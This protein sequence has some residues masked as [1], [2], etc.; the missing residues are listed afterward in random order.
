MQ[1]E[2]TFDVIVPTFERAE[3]LER[4]LAGLASQ[5]LAPERI[6]VI[7]RTTDE[8]SARVV[9]AARTQCGWV[10]QVSVS[11]AGVVVSMNT[12][13]S[14]CHSDIVAITDD[15][16]VPRP[17]WLKQL[18][19]HYADASVVGVGGRDVLPFNVPETEVV[20]AI[21]WSGRVHGEH[22]RGVGPAR[23]V[24]MLKGVNSSYRREFL[25]T[26]GFDPNLR[27]KGATT[28]W[29]LCLGAHAHER[30]LKLIYDPSILVEHFPEERRSEPRRGDYQREKF[31]NEAFNNAYAVYLGQTSLE[32]L[33]TLV[34]RLIVGSRQRPG[35]TWIVPCIVRFGVGQTLQ[36]H[37]ASIVAAIQGLAV[38]RATDGEALTKRSNLPSSQFAVVATE[39]RDSKASAIDAANQ[40]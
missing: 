28:D 3:S 31:A 34:Q 1:T 11:E 4:C 38:A 24:R 7:V 8:A 23:A 18:A 10:K 5:T 40:R 17:E 20:G 39:Q 37:R 22:H 6:V 35:L 2:L 9:S 13:L 15:D 12:G 14:E 33:A 32:R 29:E 27:G 16:A 36:R 21:S 30:G 26:V 19:S 25:Q